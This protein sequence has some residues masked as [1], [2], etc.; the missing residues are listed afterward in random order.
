M[1]R[2]MLLR[3]AK[4]ETESPS[5]QDHD[6]RLDDRGHRDATEIGGWIGRHP[7]FP[8]RV[9]VSPA[10]RAYQTWEIA[11]EAMK[12]L[13]PEPEVEFLPELYGADPTEL[14]HTIRMASVSDPKHLMLVGHNPGMHELALTL[15][16]SGDA[17]AK[18]ALDHNL[19]TSGLAIFD[20]PTEEWTDVA[21][22]RGKLVLFVSPKL[23]K[24]TSDD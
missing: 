24:Q 6:R 22:R 12:G 19:P 2:L 14:L 4:T 15:I 10:V 16:G 8:D 7:P 20:F 3:H 18:K 11:W 21:F 9:L 13:V 5:G 17:A 1:R 23:L